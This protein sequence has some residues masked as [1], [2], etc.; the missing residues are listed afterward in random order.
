MSD[1][2][3]D[4]FATVVQPPSASLDI[5]VPFDQENQEPFSLYDGTISTDNNHHN[6]S[7]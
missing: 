3:I 1:Q 4:R 7:P 2:V 5:Y 6:E